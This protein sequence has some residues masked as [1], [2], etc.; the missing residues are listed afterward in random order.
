MRACA[1]MRVC[2][3]T[4]VRVCEYACV[5]VCT[6]P[7][8]VNHVVWVYVSIL[9]AVIINMINI[10]PDCLYISLQQQMIILHCGIKNYLLSCLKPSP[11]TPHGG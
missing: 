2:I 6:N 8:R 10:M 7:E 11:F 9:H 4:R 3:H 5:F 1:C